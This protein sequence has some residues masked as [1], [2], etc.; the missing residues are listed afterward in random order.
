MTW[1]T[2]ASVLE[3][4]R[5]FDNREVWDFFVE[6]FRRPIVSFARGMEL[7]QADAEDA[8]HETLLAFARAPL[9][10]RPAHHIL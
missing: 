4:L 1:I 8:A 7:R 3:K 10:T 5:E 2:T 6:R 9:H